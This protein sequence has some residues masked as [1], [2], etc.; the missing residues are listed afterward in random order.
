MS[1][2]LTI[3]CLVLFTTTG[4]A[5]QTSNTS[6][7]LPG[8]RD[9]STECPRAKGFYDTREKFEACIKAAHERNK[10]TEKEI[11][12]GDTCQNRFDDFKERLKSLETKCTNY[13]INSLGSCKIKAKG[14]DEDSI[15]KLGEISFNP[16]IPSAETDP[17][18]LEEMI[19]SCPDIMAGDIKDWRERARDGR[20]RSD[21]LQRDLVKDQGEL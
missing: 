3:V 18:E 13:G 5:N 2:L 14:C 21:E 8:S 20:K 10:N 9:Y 11:R 12:S 1:K 6:V 17:D 16:D 19:K 15:G 4:E 7:Q